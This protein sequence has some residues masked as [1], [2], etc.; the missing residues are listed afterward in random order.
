MY[1]ISRK[2]LNELIEQEYQRINQGKTEKREKYFHKWPNMIDGMYKDHITGM[3]FKY[4]MVVF[5]ENGR[6]ERLMNDPS[7]IEKEIAKSIKLGREYRVYGTNKKLL[8]W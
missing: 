1:G 8:A 2:E 4:Y 6:E 7:D 3:V 5:R